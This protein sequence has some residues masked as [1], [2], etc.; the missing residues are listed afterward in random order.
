[1]KSLSAP[2]P[3]LQNLERHRERDLDI[4]WLIGGA[5]GGAVSGFPRWAPP[6]SAHAH[7]YG[8]M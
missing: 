6:K 7:S 2:Y 1:M 4:G 3:S 5:R 8:L